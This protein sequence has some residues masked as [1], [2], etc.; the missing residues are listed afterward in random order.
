ML[1]YVFNEMYGIKSE[2]VIRGVDG[3]D[4]KLFDFILAENQL[5][6]MCMNRR[7]DLW[8]LCG[9]KQALSR[10]FQVCAHGSH[11]YTHVM[12]CDY[13]AYNFCLIS[14]ISC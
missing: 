13:S 6:E 4:N 14:S 7:V 3:G 10:D 12:G 8:R 11:S 5:V 2:V 9:W 1:H